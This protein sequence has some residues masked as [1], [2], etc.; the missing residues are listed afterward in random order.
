MAV[1]E[2]VSLVLH[3]GRHPRLAAEHLLSQ[4]VRPEGA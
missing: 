1:V 4:P 2:Q 3:A